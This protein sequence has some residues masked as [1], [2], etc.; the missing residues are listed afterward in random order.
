ME[1]FAFV[2]HPLDPKRDAARKYPFLARV[3]PTALINLLARQ[4]PPMLLSHVVGVRSQETG[5]MVEGWLLACPLTAGQMLHLPPQTVYDKVVRAGRLAQRQGARILGLGAF[6]SVVGDGGVTIAQ[7]LTMPVTTGRSL[8]VGLA[9]EALTQVSEQQGLEMERAT[10]AVVG[11]S[12]SIGL[13]S[14]EMLAPKVQKLIL[15]GR[16]EIRLSQARAQAEAAGAA[17]VQVSTDVSDVSEADVVLS[18]TSASQPILCPSHFRKN[19]V[20][21]DVALPPDVSPRVKHEREDVSVISGGVVLVPGSVDFGFDF[22]LPAGQAY[23]CMAEAIVLA[24][25]GRYESFSLGQDIC[26][27]KVREITRLA[28]KH[29]FQ[30]SARGTSVGRCNA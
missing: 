30:L 1:N 23:A 18:A 22:G 15:L 12:G 16:R 13:A 6:T 26:T 2:I 4:W 14:A 21:C 25:E 19:A 5:K 11:A 9:V 28:H 10:A 20:V 27:E 3:L 24:L 17:K 29:G 7:R 8:T